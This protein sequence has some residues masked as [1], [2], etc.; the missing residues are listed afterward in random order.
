M[1]LKHI[2]L[3]GKRTDRWYHLRV[4]ESSGNLYS[5]LAVATCLRLSAFMCRISFPHQ[6]MDFLLF[7]LLVET[8]PLDHFW[9][10]LLYFWLISIYFTGLNLCWSY[11]LKTA[12]FVTVELSLYLQLCPYVFGQW[13]V[14][15][16]NTTSFKSV[17]MWLDC[18]LLSLFRG[19][20]K[21]ISLPV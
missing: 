14:F 2:K 5:M 11:L 18:M 13:H 15:Y 20:H 8:L 3:W 1:R 10:L 7:L 17:N 6:I 4:C 19:F 12:G 9:I 16:T 21:S